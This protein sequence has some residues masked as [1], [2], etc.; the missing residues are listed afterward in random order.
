MNQFMMGPGIFFS[1]MLFAFLAGA[2][3]FAFWIWMIID[4]IK[5][6]FKKDVE[7]VVWILV[8]V[9]LGF[10]GALIYFFVVK[11]HDKKKHKK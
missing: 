11:I 2:I 1:F 7:K 8:I 5:R 9:L 10:L 6:D 3:L 4:C